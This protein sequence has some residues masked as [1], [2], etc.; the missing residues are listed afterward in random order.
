MFVF[1]GLSEFY[2]MD[3]T[4]GVITEKSSVDLL[5]PS[6]PQ[7]VN[8]SGARCTVKFLATT[9]VT[10]RNYTLNV[11]VKVMFFSLLHDH[12]V[13]LLGWSGMFSVHEPMPS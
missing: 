5:T 1:L 13:L 2:Y 10:G 4:Q 8:F 3:S 6:Y 11:Q 9:V 12:F 7:L